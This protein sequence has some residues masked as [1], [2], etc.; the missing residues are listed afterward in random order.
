MGPWPPLVERPRFETVA[1]MRR[2][3]ITRHQLRLGI[4]VE[5]DMGDGLLLVPD[6]KGPFP[7]VLVV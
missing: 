3:N 2:E 5:G 6:G 4:A 1:T 7:A